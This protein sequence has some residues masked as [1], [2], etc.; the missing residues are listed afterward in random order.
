MKLQ[1]VF[2]NGNV[3]N[4]QL[5]QRLRLLDE[6]VFFGC[7]NE[8]K[9]NRDWWVMLNTS[10]RIIAYCSC[11]YSDGVCIFTRA[12]VHKP[13]RGKGFQKRMIDCR[14]RAAK[15]QGCITVI[16]YT[17]HNNSYSAN[18]LLDKGFRLYEPQYAYAGRDVIYFQKVIDG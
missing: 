5:Y 8:F 18:N 14:I 6:E 11:S 17:L 16:T 9:D 10:G 7:G 2:S 15:K 1:K 4:H 3:L 13:Y 12:W